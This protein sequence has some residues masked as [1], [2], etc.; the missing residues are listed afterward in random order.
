VLYGP[1]GDL[2]FQGGITMSRGHEGDNP[3]RSALES[4]VRHKLFNQVRT[5]VYGC[6]L[7]STHC[8][9]PQPNSTQ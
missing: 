5:S 8:S 6:S 1:Q 2:L 9:Q 7:L 4:L 3:G